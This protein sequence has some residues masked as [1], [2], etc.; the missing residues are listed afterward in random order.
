M[1]STNQQEIR[2]TYLMEYF[3]LIYLLLVDRL[4]GNITSVQ[5]DF[6]IIIRSYQLTFHKKFKM[7]SNVA[8]DCFSLYEKKKWKSRKGAKALQ[9]KPMQQMV[10]VVQYS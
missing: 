9:I 8:S 6:C 4:A 1:I 7:K 5:E 2:L 10:M 3:L